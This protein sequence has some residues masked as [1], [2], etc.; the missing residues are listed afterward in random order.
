M[1]YKSLKIKM[2]LNHLVSNNQMT[3]PNLMLQIYMKSKNSELSDKFF[4]EQASYIDFVCKKL[5]ISPVQAVLLSIFMIE[6]DKVKLTDIRNFLGF[7]LFFF[8][9]LDDLINR[10]FIRCHKTNDEYIG[11]INSQAEKAI[12]NNEAFSP[13][14]YSNSSLYDFFELLK[15]IF[16]E[17]YTFDEANEEVKLFIENNSQLNSIQYLKNQNLSEAEQILFLY[18]VYF[19]I[20]ENKAVFVLSEVKNHEVF[21]S[22]I[23]TILLLSNLEASKLVKNDMVERIVEKQIYKIKKSV[24]KQ[25]LANSI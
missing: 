12:A 5:T 22:S 1:K 6:K 25:F 10:K 8:D 4:E 23:D 15:M 13:T 20:I 19:F 3:L 18:F 16:T 21:N 17:S 24:L 2:L 9:E 11:I 7:Y 14:D